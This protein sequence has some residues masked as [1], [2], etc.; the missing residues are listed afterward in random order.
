MK[1]NTESLLSEEHQRRIL[2]EAQDFACETLATKALRREGEAA[3]SPPPHE[4][5]ERE[6]V[7]AWEN[8]GDPN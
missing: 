2:T 3:L 6:A 7:E 8:E 5:T 4:Q 1:S